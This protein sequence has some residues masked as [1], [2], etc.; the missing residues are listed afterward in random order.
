MSEF[1]L[2]VGRRVKS[3]RKEKGL[4]QEELAERADLQYSYI[5]G[6]GRGERNIS[7]LS[8]Q[9]VLKALEVTPLVFFSYNKLDILKEEKHKD[10]LLIKHNQLLHT[11]NS[12]EI[13]AINQIVHNILELK[14][15][16]K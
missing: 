2:L 3:I 12:E 7:L 5:G 11:L 1:L 9:K 4:T 14:R 15:I 6:I 16:S 13:V 10:E 8:F